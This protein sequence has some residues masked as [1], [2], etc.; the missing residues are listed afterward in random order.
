MGKWD[1]KKIREIEVILKLKEKRFL[2]K[3]KWLILLN[4][5]VRFKE[6]G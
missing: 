2:R 6:W 4:I 3:K 1:K 5:I